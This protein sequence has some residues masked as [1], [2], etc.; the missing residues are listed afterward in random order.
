MNDDL[1]IESIER[2]SNFAFGESLKQRTKEFALRCIRLFR[3]L[4]KQAD[5]YILGKQLLRS[6]T[7]VAANYRAACRAR[8]NAE[9]VAKIGIALEEADESLFWIELLEEAEIVT[10]SRLASLKQEAN[11]LTAILV[12]IRKS[13]YK[14]INS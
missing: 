9:F 5:A 12:T 3:A 13:S 11:E 8:S 6:A 2:V 14:R 4:P 7:S 10:A 1:R